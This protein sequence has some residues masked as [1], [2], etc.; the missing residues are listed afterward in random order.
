MQDMGYDVA[1]YK[2]V[3]PLFGS[4]T[5]FDAIVARAH[6]LGLKVIIDQVLSHTS[7]QHEW[8]RASITSTD[9]AYADWYVWADPN[10]DG[11]PPNNWP[12]VFGGSAWEWNGTRQQ[13]YLH[14]FL[15]SQPDLNFHN[16][17]VQDAML[18]VLRF[19]LDR[20]V[21]GF[22]FDTVNYYFHDTELRDNPPA[23][24]SAGDL[25]PRDPYGMQN[26]LHSKN[27]PENIAFLE[28]IRRLM[29]E[30]PGT[31][32]VGEVG[33]AHHALNLMAAYTAGEKRLHMC[34]S[35]E[36][37]GPRYSP[38]FIRSRVEQFFKAAADGWPCW[39]FSN[40][41]V[42]RHVTRWREYGPDADAVARQTLALLLSLRG[43][44]CLYQGEELGLTE[45]ELEFHELTDPPGI[46]FWPDYRGRDGC[47]TPIPWE[48]GPPP[49]GFTTGTPWLPIKAPQSARNVARQNGFPDSVLAFYRRAL[50]LRRR[51][52]ALVDG[53]ITFLEAGERVLA[54]IRAGADGQ[55]L[56]CVF[57]LSA[58]ISSA[59]LTGFYDLSALPFQEGVTRTGD[60]LKFAPGAFGYFEVQ[61]NTAERLS[62]S[63]EPTEASLPSG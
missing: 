36:M 54:F 49:N 63:E 41:D 46:R 18:D 7:S 16:A 58:E 3:D 10:T 43:S 47:R 57:N 40:H 27:R 51:H 12:S 42:V 20:G 32:T 38:A 15:P 39:S 26:H 6:A 37:L 21:D 23:E 61:T 60:V 9:N 62:V 19:W 30:Y 17:D 1:D 29:D 55:A 5:D 33:D 52:P 25:L 28:R 4:L 59:S 14:N 35:F 44:V 45:T 2:T 31:T 22:R 56:L 50:A 53:D 8:F 11:S 13:Y 48:D 34:Y 24:I